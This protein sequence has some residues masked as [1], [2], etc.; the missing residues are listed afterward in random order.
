MLQGTGTALVADA[1]EEESLEKVGIQLQALGNI[2]AV[3]GLLTP[4]PDEVREEIADKGD[5]IET[6]GVVIA[7][8]AEIEE[9]F[10][11]AVFFELFGQILQVIEIK[12]VDEA[13]QTMISEWS[14]TF[15]SILA[16]ID[17]SQEEL[18]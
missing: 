10:S 13:L 18:R 14:Q 6:L 9:G 3:A 17:V 12:G 2:I 15:A 16:L 7:A 4:L 1:M 11:L 5:I 8:P